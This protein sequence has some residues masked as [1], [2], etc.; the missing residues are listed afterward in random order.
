[1]VAYNAG[2]G[3]SR[4]AFG[5]ASHSRSGCA[6]IVGLDGVS[7]PGTRTGDGLAVRSAFAFGCYRLLTQRSRERVGTLAFAAISAASSAIVLAGYCLVTRLP[8]G[9]FE[10]RSWLALAL[11]GI[12]TQVGGYFAVGK[13]LGALSAATVS[14]SLLLPAVVTAVLAVVVLGDRISPAAFVGGACVLIGVAVVNVPKRGA[15]DAFR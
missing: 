9:G 15:V 2:D 3:C 10:A 7:A 6:A 11:L 1:M 4:S 14:V 8:L 13:A 5:S 12:V